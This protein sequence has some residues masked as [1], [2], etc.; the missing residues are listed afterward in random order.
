MPIKRRS[1]AKK[2]ARTRAGSGGAPVKS[3]ARL[4]SSEEKHQLILAHVAAHRSI[5]PIQRLSLWAGVTV[6]MLFVL[7]AWMYT[8]GSGIKKSIA[9]PIDPNLKAIVTETQQFAEDTSQGLGNIGEQVSGVAERLEALNQEQ[10][11]LNAMVLQL[12]TTSSAATNS[13]STSELF[14]PKIPSK[15]TTSTSP[16]TP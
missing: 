5:D 7:G 8:V 12:S 1:P 6:C 10:A 4:L 3:A 13:T 2:P 16:L 11:L 9:G 14:K 15:A